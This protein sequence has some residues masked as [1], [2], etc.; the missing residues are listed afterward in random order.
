MKPKHAIPSLVLA[1]V[2]AGVGMAQA[3]YGSPPGYSYPPA[4]PTGPY[5]PTGPSGPYGP[6]GY[7]GPTGPT[8][9]TAPAPAKVSVRSSKLGKILVDGSGRTLYFFSLDTGG[10]SYCTGVCAQ[11]WPPL[12]TS[13]S[14]Q[15]G[16][17][18]KHGKLKTVARADGTQQVTYAQHPLYTFA[19]DSGSGSVK[20]QAKMEFGGKWYAISRTGKKAKKKRA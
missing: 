16:R 12:L 17:G 1:A 11:S 13:G 18:V 4:G 2:L 9:P 14:P 19:G 5:G 10:Q 8:G 3:Q 20:G 15:P 6:T 7:T